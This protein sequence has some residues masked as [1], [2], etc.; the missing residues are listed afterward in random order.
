MV[1]VT[2]FDRHGLAYSFSKKLIRREKSKDMLLLLTD[3]PE[4][5]GDIHRRGLHSK[6]PLSLLFGP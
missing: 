4:F 6:S 5:G 2:F 1:F 3:T